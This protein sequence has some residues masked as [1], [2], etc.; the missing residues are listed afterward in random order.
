MIRRG[1]LALAV[2]ALVA[3]TLF[4]GTLDRLW[5][6][7]PTDLT[8]PREATV[9][10][11]RAALEARGV[12]LRGYAAAVALHVDEAA[13]SWVERAFGRDVARAQVAGGAPLVGQLV[14]WKRAGDP[15]VH[16]VWLHAERGP[17]A[18]SSAL[19][20]D[21]PAPAVPAD[22]A[23]ALAREALVGLVDEPGR[24]ELRETV[25]T[26]RPHRV[27]RRYRFERLRSEEPELREQ[28]EVTVAG[29]R[30][31]RAARAWDVPAAEQRRL[32]RAAA[33]AVALETLGVA[34]LVA[35]L[36]AAC[37]IA[38]RALRAG[39]VALRPA[40]AGPALVLAGLVVTHL[41]DTARG[42]FAWDPLWPRW[43]A[44]FRSLA[45]DNLRTIWI[46]P[47]LLAVTLAGSAT[48]GAWRRGAS[49]R[50]AARGRLADPA[51]G[52]ASAR[53]FLV[54]LLCGGT[55]AAAA[56]LLEAFAGARVEL[57]PRG[58]FHYTLNSAAPLLT[59]LAF[60]LGVALTE[61]LGY[62]YFG[63]SWLLRRTGRR[64]IA[65]LLPAAIYG[66]THTRLDFL[67]PAEP[68]WGRAV[69]LTLVGA[70]WGWAFLRWDALTVVLSHF[71]ADLF[72]FNAPL[73]ASPH[74]ATRAWAAATVAV[75]LVPA[76]L[77]A[78]VALGRAARR[79]R[80]RA[81]GPAPGRPVS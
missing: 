34:L 52:A 33:P 60:F 37:A 17:L 59:S 26:A 6:L 56:L 31:A 35:G 50:L 25:E 10:D 32:R 47:V 73:L 8:R 62:R 9:R 14:H 20:E 23:L 74:P 15:T 58:F 57:Q 38:L 44:L 4:F 19:E 5:P 12:D 7:P 53:G 79:R 51:V 18:W 80:R 48:D 49:L 22:A 78:A 27:D 11:A 29:D 55:L 69:A 39:T 71:T 63:G 3:G 64:W 40:L 24:F 30:V 41:L 1:D 70:V 42:F 75:P 68:W 67:P 43:I 21:A 2:A 81:G 13:L 61:E 66:L 54:G 16:R 36:L 77:A 46:L 28:V 45:E 76:A 72:V 65:I